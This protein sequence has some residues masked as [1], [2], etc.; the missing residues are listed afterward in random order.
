MPWLP[1]VPLGAEG[2]RSPLHWLQPQL[3][4]GLRSAHGLGALTGPRP[5]QPPLTAVGSGRRL[6]PGSGQRERVDPR[7]PVGPPGASRS[8]PQMLWLKESVRE[9]P[10]SATVRGRG[11]GAGSG[12]RRVRAKPLQREDGEVPPASVRASPHGNHRGPPQLHELLSPLQSAR[13]TCNPEEPKRDF[14]WATRLRFTSPAVKS[15][16]TWMDD[17]SRGLWF[18][19]WRVIVR[20]LR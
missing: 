15:C 9:Q 19:R 12:R 11:R 5:G 8:L 18:R 14:L 17:G 3:H 4:V 10:T 2:G 1:C 6:R 13:F 20:E 7:N 16:T